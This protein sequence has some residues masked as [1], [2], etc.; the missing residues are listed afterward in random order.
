[1]GSRDTKRRQDCRVRFHQGPNFQPVHGVL[2][3]YHPNGTL[4]Q[5]FSGSLGKFCLLLQSCGK[6]K[7]NLG[8][9]FYDYPVSVALRK[10]DGT[11]DGKIVVAGQFGLARFNANGSLDKDL[12]NSG[13]MDT[14]DNTGDAVAIL[15]K[16]Q[17]ARPRNSADA[18]R[19]RR[20]G[21]RVT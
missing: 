17:G 10:A 11:E 5:S 1:M 9:G 6:I 12:A 19:P 16:R 7:V 4:D 18:A 21:D 14:P 8:G 2:A 13:I 3:R 15:G 20:R